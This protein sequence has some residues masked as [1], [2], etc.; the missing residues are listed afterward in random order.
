MGK[1]CELA[2]LVDAKRLDDNQVSAHVNS[3]AL[4]FKRRRGSALITGSNPVLA[5]TMLDDKSSLNLLPCCFG[6]SQFS[7]N[8]IDANVIRTR[9]S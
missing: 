1:Y 4:E 3:L 6:S 8:R 5:T 9:D 2:E 7:H